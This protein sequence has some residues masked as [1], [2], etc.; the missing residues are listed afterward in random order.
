MSA[1]TIDHESNRYGTVTHD[2]IAVELREDAVLTGRL[3]NDALRADGYAE[4]AA[5]GTTTDGRDARVCWLHVDDGETL[6]E[7]YDWSDVDRVEI[8]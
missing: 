6:P 5:R 1:T 4:W 3:L 7:D 8:G 2:G